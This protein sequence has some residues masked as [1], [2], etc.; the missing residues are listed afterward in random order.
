MALRYLILG[1]GLPF[2]EF[3]H[4]VVLPQMFLSQSPFPILSYILKPNTYDNG[5]WTKFLIMV[6]SDWT[7]LCILTA[8]NPGDSGCSPTHHPHP[9]VHCFC[10]GLKHQGAELEPWGER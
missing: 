10:P 4:L 2:P 6:S 8:M 7:F 9:Q 1:P 5:A 3:F